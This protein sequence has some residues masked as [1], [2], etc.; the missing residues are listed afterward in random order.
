MTLLSVVIITLNE[1][2]NIGRCL[3]SVRGIADDVVV[4]D[5]G[6]ADRTGEICREY[7]ARFVTHPWQGFA[8]TKN[9]ANSLALHPW[10]LS[11]DADEALSDEL[12]D[13]VQKIKKEGFSEVVWSMN[14]L[15][16]YCGSWIK[17]CGWYPDKKIRL[18][19][20][21]TARWAGLL[22]HETL[23]I[24][25]GIKVN[26]LK[27]DLLHFSYYTIGEHV[28]QA[29]RYTDL[30]AEEAISK[31]KSAGCAG[32]IFK[33]LLRFIRDYFFRLGFMDGYYGYVICRISAHATFLKYSKIRQLGRI[34]SSVGLKQDKRDSNPGNR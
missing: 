11:L 9:F 4:V 25:T 33:P 18:F 5:S 21:D 34:R 10:I 22:I 28:A 30:A 16:N 12:R 26:H 20:R 29:N 13:S 27:G 6:S 17:H 32:I 31:G 15:T 14:R 23:E 8:E 3:A 2:R 7:G 1:E 19:H 24:N